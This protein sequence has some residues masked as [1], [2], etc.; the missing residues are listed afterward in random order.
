[1]SNVAPS[2]NAERVMQTLAVHYI[3]RYS[4]CAGCG[5]VLS[6]QGI[7]IEQHQTN[8][9]VAMGLIKPDAGTLDR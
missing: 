2:S 1:V 8:L 3:G 9:L 6:N 4:N 5:T 7:T